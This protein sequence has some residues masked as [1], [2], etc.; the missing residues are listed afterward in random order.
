VAVGA[1]ATA[2][3]FGLFWLLVRAHVLVALAVTIAYFLATAAQFFVNRHWTFQAFDRAAG[4]QARTY[5][6]IVLV[7]W[8]VAVGCVEFGVRWLGLSPLLAKAVSIPPSAIVGFAGNRYLTFGPG[9]RA[10]WRSLRDR[11]R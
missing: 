4:S 5:A 3:D 2:L 10:T 7:S 11:L 1:G 8:L 9:I 6:V